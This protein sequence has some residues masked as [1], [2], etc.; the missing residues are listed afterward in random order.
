[1]RAPPPPRKS[2]GRY[3]KQASNYILKIITLQ[4]LR[5]RWNL[6]RIHC[7]DRQV[8]FKAKITR[9]RNKNGVIRKS[10]NQFGSVKKRKW[11]RKPGKTNN[12]KKPLLIIDYNHYCTVKNNVVGN[13]S[14]K[15]NSIKPQ[16]SADN[17]ND[18][19]TNNKQNNYPQITILERSTLSKLHISKRKYKLKKLNMKLTST[20]PE[21][22]LQ[23]KF[24]SIDINDDEKEELLMKT[25]QEHHI[26]QKLNELADVKISLN[27]KNIIKTTAIP[28]SNVTTDAN[29]RKGDQ[30]LQIDKNFFIQLP[31]DNITIDK[32][33]TESNDNTHQSKNNK[34]SNYNIDQEKYHMIEKHP[35]LDMIRTPYNNTKLKI[36]DFLN[37]IEKETKPNMEELYTD[38]IST[39]RLDSDFDDTMLLSGKYSNQYITNNRSYDRRSKG[40]D[41]LDEVATSSDMIN[42]LKVAHNMF[43]NYLE[44][45]TAFQK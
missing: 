4:K 15:Q 39:T 11:Y 18:I 17:K 43:N 2:K 45:K 10:Y 34:N 40:G 22:N 3:F 19:T 33:F 24:S 8:Q 37:K 13:N 20:F 28:N 16:I 29:N 6:H 44:I 38:G 31:R 32:L 36:T 26:Y 35:H 5:N 25:V 7:F 14:R 27:K 23:D 1:M 12:S 42:S 30:R 41:K 21:P 9:D